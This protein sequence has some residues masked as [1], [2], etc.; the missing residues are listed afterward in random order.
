MKRLSGDQKGCEALSVPPSRWKETAPTRRTYSDGCPEFGLATNAI[1]CPS[2]ERAMSAVFKPLTGT[3]N[4]NGPVLPEPRRYSAAGTA[5][6]RIR[7][8]AVARNTRARV[9]SLRAGAPAARFL[10]SVIQRS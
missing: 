6:A 9:P 10:P 2:G 7:S 1:V 3:R 5:I 8:A 4:W